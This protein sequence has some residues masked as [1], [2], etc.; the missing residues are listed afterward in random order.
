MKKNSAS[1]SAICNPRSL[2]A[3]TLCSVGILLAMLAPAAAADGNKQTAIGDIYQLQ[4]AF[5]RAKTFQD[6]NLMMSLWALDGKLTVQGDANSPYVG[7]SALRAFWLGSGSF[8]NHRFSLVPSFKT[9]IVVRGDE[10]YLYFECHDVGNFA[11]PTNRSIVG[12]TFLAGTLRSENGSW[13][14]TDMTAG[15]ASPLSPDHD[16]FSPFAQ[17]NLQGANFEGAILPYADLHG[18]NLQGANLQGA[19]LEGANLQGANL[20]GS[21][22]EDSNLTGA[23]LTGATMQGANLHEVTWSNTTCPDGTNSNNDGGTCVHN[24]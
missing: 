22:L 17:T 24:L 10:A 7:T 4:A 14:F 23:N 9:Q 6:I 11:D 1:Q 13:V 16:Y 21:N 19:S 20:Q 15:K 8:K 3:S 2:V 5:H 18:A 12:D